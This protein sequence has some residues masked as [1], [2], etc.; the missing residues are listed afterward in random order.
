MWL[1]LTESYFS[2]PLLRPY[3]QQSVPSPVRNLPCVIVSLKEEWKEKMLWE[4]WSAKAVKLVAMPRGW[5]V[6]LFVQKS[7]EKKT[8]QSAIGVGTQLKPDCVFFLDKWYS[9]KV[10]QL[11]LAL[12]VHRQK[13][14]AGGLAGPPA[15]RGKPFWEMGFTNISSSLHKQKHNNTRRVALISQFMPACFPIGASALMGS[16]T[17][18][19]AL[20]GLGQR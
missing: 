9:A 2:K 13:V 3:A 15:V 1:W 12:R 17:S 16:H 10:P 18:W 7:R 5:D 20:S 4:C 19:P 8:L 14:P 6:L 11:T